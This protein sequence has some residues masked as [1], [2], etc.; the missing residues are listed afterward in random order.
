LAALARGLIHNNEEA[1]M[2]FNNDLKNM[3]SPAEL[4]NFF[5]LCTINGYLTLP[6]YEDVDDRKYLYD[7]YLQNAI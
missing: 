3:S 6:I 2:S 4:R 1:I 5:V 7:D